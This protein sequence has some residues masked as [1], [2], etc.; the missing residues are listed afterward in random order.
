MTK[1]IPFGLILAAILAPVPASSQ[2][3]LK[4]WPV[5]YFDSTDD[6]DPKASTVLYSTSPKQ[7]GCTLSEVL[8]I[9]NKDHNT[10]TETYSVGLVF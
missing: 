4:P 3:A 6:M 1:R 5:C 9:V 8:G 2:Y 10:N 7:I